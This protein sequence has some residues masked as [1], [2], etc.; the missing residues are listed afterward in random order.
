MATGQEGPVHRGWIASLSTGETVL[1]T[2]DVPGEKS[3]WQK[4]C[5]WCYENKVHL[6]QLRLQLGTVNL[7]GL[8]QKQAQGY[9]Q[10]WSVQ[11][12]LITG[13]QLLSRGLGSVVG[14]Q[15]YIIWVAQDGQ[16]SL[17]IVP[18]PDMRMHCIL[19]GGE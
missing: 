10:L 8:S 17:E 15:V 12:N 18:L 13:Q 14:D 5:A 11:R 16:T 6:T 4:L 9:C 7:I 3:A 19:R 2:P 1:E